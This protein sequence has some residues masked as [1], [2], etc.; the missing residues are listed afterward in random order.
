MMLNQ[1]QQLGAVLINQTKDIFISFL[2][3]KAVIEGQMT[4]GMMMAIQ[5][6]IGQLNAPIQQFIGFTQAA[7]DARISLER[8]G[9]IHN[10]E[11]EE[12]PEDDK[13]REIPADKDIEIKNLFFQYEGPHSEKVLN[14]VSL[15]IPAKKIT[16]IVGISGSGKTTLLKL[17]LGFYEPVKGEISLNGTPLK[18]FCQAEWRK[19]CGVVMQEGYI[20]ADSISGNIGLADDMPDKEKT[21][22]AAK[23]ANIKE[24]IDSLPLGYNTRIGNDGQGL[25]T[26]QK[27]RLL[28]ARAV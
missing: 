10:R 5:Y 19:R 12:K 24:Y 15:T 25:S 22:R 28:I 23:T 27:Q 1:N 6:I 18:R 14:N 21:D 9:E 7:Q 2:S 4:L 11:D 16:A 3:A 20:F 26:G 13:I 8:L 17:M